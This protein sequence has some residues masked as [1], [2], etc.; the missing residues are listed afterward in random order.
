MDG[1]RIIDS[2]SGFLAS[3]LH[4]KG[5]LAEPE[6][7]L[8]RLQAD[9]SPA[10]A[11]PLAGKKILISAG[12]TREHLDP[13]RFLTNGSTGTMG[14]ALARA[15]AAAGADVTLIA[16]PVGLRCIR[17]PR[18]PGPVG[19]GRGQRCDSA[20]SRLRWDEGPGFGRGRR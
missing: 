1:I 14:F 16:G 17:S 11:S 5:R 12:P 15:C 2:D 20:C 18:S 3:G 6:A 7:I 9:P 13:V 4:G 8:A 19:R 10:E